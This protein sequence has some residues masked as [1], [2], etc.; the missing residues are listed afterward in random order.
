MAKYLDRLIQ[1]TKKTPY[2]Y[3]FLSFGN[4]KEALQAPCYPFYPPPDMS[5]IRKWSRHTPQRDHN[6]IYLMKVLK[7]QTKTGFGPKSVFYVY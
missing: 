4:L 2:Y 1:N 6:K 3:T 7:H 5:N